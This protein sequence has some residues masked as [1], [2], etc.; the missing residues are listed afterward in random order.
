MAA[1]TP[2]KPTASRTPQS[3]G[4]VIQGSFPHGLPVFPARGIATQARAVPPPAAAL[5]GAR[6]QVRAAQATALQP[7][8]VAPRAPQHAVVQR[9]GQDTALQLPANL[10]QFGRGGG[11]PLP[12]PVRE[13]MESFF[14]ASFSDVRVHVGPHAPAIGAVAFTHGSN[15][16]FAPGQY[17][18]DS[19]R[20]QQLIGH[21]LAHVIQQRSGRVRNPFGA[22]VAVVQDRMLEA[23]A[24][25]AGQ[26]FAQSQLLI[27]A[28]MPRV[29]TPRAPVRKPAALQ[30]KRNRAFVIQRM[31]G[32]QYVEERN[33]GDVKEALNMFPRISDGVTAGV[34]RGPA[35]RFVR[36]RVNF[37]SLPVKV[38][39]MILEI[40]ASDDPLWASAGVA[41]SGLRDF[42][43]NFGG[44]LPES[45]PAGVVGAKAQNYRQVATDSY[46]DRID[47]RGR[48]AQYAEFH[49]NTSGLGKAFRLLYDYVNNTFYISI[50][51]YN[52][53][54][55][56]DGAERNPFFEVIGIP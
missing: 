14:G 22:G 46:S 8:L 56:P 42:H 16:Y 54:R 37:N 32:P 26:S 38:K 33:A 34:D 3:G 5:S 31:Q 24:E 9:K 30:L 27:Q 18:P 25:R 15:I 39:T 49:I 23:E 44:H 11:Q 45:D 12:P 20:G 2:P 53:W 17:N 41:E 7:R 47:K 29:P 19:A 1:T 28:K 21:E 43:A 40:N 52:I 51:H 36:G 48:Q 6:G 4:S 35:G 13:R 10:T 55:G 50:S